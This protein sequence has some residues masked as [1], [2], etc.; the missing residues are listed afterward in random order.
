M[1]GKHMVLKECV[2]RETYFELFEVIDSGE[3]H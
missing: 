1:E 3:I 2:D